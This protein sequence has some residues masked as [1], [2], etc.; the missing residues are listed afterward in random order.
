LLCFLCSKLKHKLFGFFL[1][2]RT[3]TFWRD[4]TAVE[5]NVREIRK[6]LGITQI[7][8]AEDL[9]ITR[10]TMTAI[11]TNKYNPSLGLA[12][13]IKEYFNVPIE[14]IFQLKEEK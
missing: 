14:E 6:K 13:K 2:K 5:K 1:C 3:F 4:R 7:K 12:L 9:K 10:Q 11:E 8:M